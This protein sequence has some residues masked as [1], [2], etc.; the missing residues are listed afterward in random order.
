MAS[1]I[2]LP[3][4]RMENDFSPPMPYTV[5]YSAT[6]KSTDS[7]VEE[8]ENSPDVWSDRSSPIT[9]RLNTGF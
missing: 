5:G 1:E 2:V 3:F 9:V 7:L 4:I 6:F 8:V